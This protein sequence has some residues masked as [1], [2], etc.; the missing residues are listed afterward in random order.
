MEGLRYNVSM[1]SQVLSFNF[2]AGLFSVQNAAS[3]NKIY[4][5][6]VQSVCGSL[7]DGSKAIPEISKLKYETFCQDKYSTGSRCYRNTKTM[8]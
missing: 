8:T 7:I 2:F 3:S 4:V 5:V 1:Y 6:D